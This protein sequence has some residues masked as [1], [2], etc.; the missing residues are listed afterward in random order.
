MDDFIEYIRKNGY[1]LINLYSEKN[2]DVLIK[3]GMCE[4]TKNETQLKNLLKY[5]KRGIEYIYTNNISNTPFGY[6]LLPIIHRVIKQDND[7]VKTEFNP[8]EI[9]KTYDSTYQQL[10]FN[11]DS[12]EKFGIDLDLEL[13]EK[14][15]KFYCVNVYDF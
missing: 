14:T 5:Y 6:C 12:F 3:I 10:I 13:C 8:S 1:D 11:K 2:D 15:A 4:G 9:K 7:W